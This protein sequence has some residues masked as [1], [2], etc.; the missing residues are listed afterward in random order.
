MFPRISRSLLR[1]MHRPLAWS[2]V[3]AALVLTV[4]VAT[5]AADSPRPDAPPTV[6]AT[7]APRPEAPPV[8]R[9]AP[10]P[11]ARARPTAV[12]HAPVAVAPAHSTTSP[13]PAHHVEAA[14]R[15]SPTTTEP[16]ARTESRPARDIEKNQV[17]LLR[18][19][20]V[21]SLHPEAPGDGRDG[22]YSLVALAAFLLVIGGCSLAVT[23][24]ELRREPA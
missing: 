17:A 1:R 20:L 5:A 18:L 11:A 24:A 19:P 16:V 14:P 22:S 12:F 9:P 15:Q 7:G 23:V 21:P 10:A 4:G 6:P 13:A 3:V 2:P 8:T